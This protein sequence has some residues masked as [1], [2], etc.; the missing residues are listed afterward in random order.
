MTPTTSTQPDRQT[1][2]SVRARLVLAA[3]APLL[4]GATSLG[5]AARLEAPQR[6]DAER[7]FVIPEGTGDRAA[8][9]QA[10]DDILPRT[11]T[12]AVGVAL[13][14]ENDDTVRHVFGPFVLDPGQAWERE[15][16]ASG[17][18]A[19]DCTLYPVAGFTIAVD[20]AP[21]RAAA[22]GTRAL[23][24]LWRGAAVLVAAAL[25]GGLGLAVATGATAGS[26]LTLLAAAL[27]GTVLTAV[28]AGLL[29]LSRLAAWRAVL[30]S[31]VALVGLAAALL[32]TAAGAVVLRFLPSE[33]RA[34]PLRALPPMLLLALAVVGLTWPA[35][36]GDLALR[37]GLLAVGGGLLAAG[38]WTQRS[39]SRSRASERAA[40]VGFATV[41]VALPLS[42]DR[43]TP[44]WHAAL[45]LPALMVGVGVLAWGSR[46]P[47]AAW[48]D[49]GW[50]A[51]A[52]GGAVAFF[53]ATMLWWAG[54]RH[55]DAVSLPL[56]GNPTADSPASVARGAALWE[57]ECVT[58]HEETET[59]PEAEDRAML[60]I[61]THGQGDMPGFAYHLD[62]DARGDLVNYLRRLREGVAPP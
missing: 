61:I 4:L 6:S 30:G 18:Y 52:V 33:H 60:E 38:L 47:A 29:A 35:L 28:G 10:V 22:R 8:A 1:R 48:P 7:R 50:L 9:G 19:F 12:T 62:L 53:G 14:V 11:I 20:E 5:I 16:A 59:L 15:F 2:G 26:P 21:A 37:S 56:W 55:L 49:A 31:R 54:I 36:P 51:R 41:L 58:C 13:V 44:P 43:L 25:A 27:P 23:A 3:L 34:S 17:D 45:A 46:H 40:M 42:L 32:A 24:G 57:A 39:R